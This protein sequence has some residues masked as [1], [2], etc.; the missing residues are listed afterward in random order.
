MSESEKMEFK[1]DNAELFKAGGKN[2]L[3]AFE[4][5]NYAD[6]EAA[7]GPA[8]EKRRKQQLEEVRQTLA[9]ERERQGEDRDEVYIAELERYEEYL[10]DTTNLFKA[11]LEL[12]LEQQQKQLDEYRD[13]LEKEKEAL[14]ESLE[15]RKEAYEKY[16]DEISKEEED[17]EYEEERDKL[18][19]NITKLASSGDA[20]SKKQ[21]M[22][23]EQQLKELEAERLQALKERARE[24]ILENM[25]NEVAEIN[26]KFDKLLENNQALLAAMNGDLQD[27][28]EFLS[29]LISNKLDDGL[30]QLEFEDYFKTLESTY[31]NTLS[32]VN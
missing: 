17:A 32:D 30:T 19:T 11:N 3:T 31:G 5:G 8:L 24:A 23:L 22:E 6:I 9:I 16:F 27:P 20:D 18:V 13:M 1:T 10:E 26:D 12:Q 4:S 25:D 28:N 21:T 7:I 15:K 2:L 14:T 29:K